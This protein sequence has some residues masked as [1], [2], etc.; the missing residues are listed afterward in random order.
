GAGDVAEGC[1]ATETGRTLLRFGVRFY[2][3]GT[4]ALVVGDPMCPVCIDN[5]DVICGD[6]RFICSPADGHNHPHYIG[7]ADYQLLDAGHRELARARKAS[8]CI[9]ESVCPDGTPIV[10]TCTYQGIQAGC[11]D[12]YPPT[13]GCQYIDVT[14]IPNVQQRALKIRVTLDS[15]ETLP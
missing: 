5:P 4:D 3:I 6:P 14:D 11:Y 7:F 10:F 9:R 12:Y 1:A 15:A 8:F 13:L 2:N